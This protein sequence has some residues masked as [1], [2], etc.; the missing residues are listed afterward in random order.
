M[1]NKLLDRLFLKIVVLVITFV[2]VER[3]DAQILTV[4]IYTP[5]TCPSDGTVVLSASG[6]TAPYQ[7]RILSGPIGLSYPTAWQASNAYASLLPGTYQFEMIDA[8]NATATVSQVVTT[9]YVAMSNMTYGQSVTHSGSCAIRNVTAYVKN[10]K[11]PFTFEL[12]QG[13]TPIY[14]ITNIPKAPTT[15]ATFTNVA[16]GT[17]DL[18]YTDGCGEVRT[19]TP[20]TVTSVD[21]KWVGITGNPSASDN[22]V[23]DNNGGKMPLPFD[24][25]KTPA[26]YRSDPYLFTC[27]SIAFRLSAV[28]TP[29]PPLT[30]NQR[31]Y[32]R[33]LNTNHIDFDI[34]Y[35]RSG[36]NPSIKL[37]INTPYRFYFDDLCNDVDSLDRNYNYS[38]GANIT[39]SPTV[40]RSGCGSYYMSL[41]KKNNW[42]AANNYATPIDT[43]TIL[44][45]TL[46]GDTM[47]GKRIIYNWTDASANSA[48]P[49]PFRF[50]GVTPNKTYTVRIQ[51]GC[52]NY[53]IT[54]KLNNVSAISVASSQGYSFPC[55]TNT[56]SIGFRMLPIIA[57]VDGYVKF[58][59]LSGPT[60]FTDTKG[61]TTAITYPII[62]SVQYLNGVAI[63]AAGNDFLNFRNF[64]EGVYTVRSINQC[65]EITPTTAFTI[66]EPTTLK[67]DA[68]ISEQ[69][70]CGLNN[71]RVIF[72]ITKAQ[73]QGNSIAFTREFWNGSSWVT[74]VSNQTAWGFLSGVVVNGYLVQGN[75]YN[76]DFNGAPGRYRFSILPSG[77]TA[78]NYKRGPVPYCDTIWSQEIVIQGYQNPE[79]STQSLGYVCNAGG[80]NG[81]ATI[82]G[83]KGAPAYTFQMLD[84]SNNVLLSQGTGI[85]NGLS[86]GTYKFRVLDACGN[87]VVTTVQVKKL[88]TPLITNSGVFCV[89]QN[90]QLNSNAMVPGV[91]YA[92]TGPGGFTASSSSVSFTP[93]VMANAGTYTV[94]QTIGACSKSNSF[95]VNVCDPLPIELTNFSANCENN[96]VTLKWT[97]A[98]ES[99][100]NRFEVLR[101]RDGKMWD[102]VVSIS[103]IGNSSTSNSYQVLDYTSADIFYYRLRSVDNDGTS[104]VFNPI[105]VTCHVENNSWGIYP[106]PVSSKATVTVSATE[107]SSNSM[108]ITDLN[109][110]IVFENKI[111]INEGSNNY[112]LDL[113]HLSDGAYFIRIEGNEHY[114]PLKFLKID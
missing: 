100:V 54:V 43:L 17:Y 57:D 73:T 20:I 106:V 39:G 68:T 69:G 25:T 30:L 85:F 18:K 63:G 37:A 21:Y 101:S 5:G 61:N 96:V 27:D 91:T 83:I 1:K 76:H 109:G 19:L 94:T 35:N 28:L 113:Q 52:H 22:P 97:T 6:G 86:E 38:T 36:G 81:T 60:S 88:E 71:I 51:N 40:G 98:T 23:T 99:N 53:I 105:A 77:Y 79:I 66:A 45:S 29:S 56:A 89:N 114:Q 80:S 31:F 7:Y 44:S 62:D 3:V 65:G 32:V 47:I 2:L 75:S 111:T 46:I 110:R 64:P 9:N 55:L 87:G 95:V 12:L 67:F 49:I 104:E 82:I 41:S 93:L 70:R 4:S 92:W 33:N 8:S 107:A 112:E 50:Y 102:K 58:Q 15:S 34:T 72:N 16:A 78:S 11:G 90:A 59:I 13:G 14:T 26:A 48:N 74:Q 108:V 84:N 24:Q 103:A 10:G 42:N